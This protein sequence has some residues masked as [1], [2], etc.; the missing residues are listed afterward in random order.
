MCFITALQTKSCTLFVVGL[1]RGKQ[2]WAICVSSQFVGEGF[3][4]SLQELLPL[5]TG[6]FRDPSKWGKGLS[7]APQK[8]L[9]QSVPKL[10]WR[11]ISTVEETVDGPVLFSC[12]FSF[13]ASSR[14]RLCS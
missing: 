13:M 12:S 4:V 2:I 5:I 1:K 7:L 3:E 9:L 14:K 6:T 11:N 10:V 8:F